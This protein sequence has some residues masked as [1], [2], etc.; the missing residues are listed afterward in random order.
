MPGHRFFTPF[1]KTDQKVILEDGD[2]FQHL[3]KVLRLKEG[4][5]VEL[6]NGQG[7]LA[8]AVVQEIRKA[9]AVIAL[10]EV[11]CV[12]RHAAV[13]I[14]LACAIPKRAKFE[15]IIEKCTELGVDRIVPLMTER[16]EFFLDGE[17]A[18]K[19]SG[20]FAR[21][22]INAAKQCKRVWFPEISEPMV[23]MTAI[24]ELS[25]PHAGLFIPWL[26]GERITLDQALAE[27]AGMKEFVFFI[28]PE[29]DFTA[30][31][32]G[33]ALKAGALPVSLGET[34]LKVDTAAM[35][36]VAFA[37]MKSL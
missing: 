13:K 32:V 16:T 4:D 23:F 14:T 24:K 36:V 10:H 20:R 15:T 12:P 35:A 21:V 25:S 19:K 30:D 28:G 29:G 9:S 34:V 7:V 18:D 17:R 3:S 26:E 37:R 27:K 6:I 1:Q 33:A 2:E 22:A 31:E 8:H 5:A 11:S